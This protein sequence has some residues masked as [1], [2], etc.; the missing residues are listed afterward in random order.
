MGSVFL[1]RESSSEDVA[2]DQL[3]KVQQGR[4]VNPCV[5]A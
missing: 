3:G 4:K 2:G 5:S 1:L